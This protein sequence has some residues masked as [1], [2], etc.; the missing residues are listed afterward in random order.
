[1]IAR[2]IGAPASAA[3]RCG[4]M[5]GTNA[6][7]L[8]SASGASTLPARCKH[9]HIGIDGTVGVDTRGHGL[10]MSPAA[11]SPGRDQRAQQGGGDDGFADARVGAG[12][13]DAARHVQRPGRVSFTIG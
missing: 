2:S 5:A 7:G 6:H 13:E 10:P 3:A 1:M 9:V 12:D 11:R 8:R 4:A